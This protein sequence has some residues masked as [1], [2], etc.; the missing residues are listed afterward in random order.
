D[1]ASPS[2]NDTMTVTF[3]GFSD[4]VLWSSLGTSSYANVQLTVPGS[5]ITGSST[6][7]AFTAT[8]DPNP[9][10]VPGVGGAGGPLNL[11]DVALTANSV[12]TPEPPAAWLMLVGMAALGGVV[13]RRRAQA[14]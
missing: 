6:S 7:L 14:G 11:D 5:D 8:I 1:Q 2:G 12:S 10:G 9:S 4:A 3:G 13:L